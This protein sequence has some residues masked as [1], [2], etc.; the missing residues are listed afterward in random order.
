[1][2]FTG[3]S[4]GAFMDRGTVS[5]FRRVG[6]VLLVLLLA[7]V[8]LSTLGHLPATRV[9]AQTTLGGPLPG[10]TTSQLN[11]FTIGLSQFD[12][13]WDPVHGLGPVY[14][15]TNCNHCHSTPVDGGYSTTNRVTLFGALN[16]DGS[17]NP[18]TNEGGIELQPLTV[19]K[20]IA[21]CTV[22]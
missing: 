7:A 4:E 10:L 11:H 14:T 16:S 5:V 12:F 8:F 21:G 3:F 17:F 1:M 13:S 18:L 6:F 2:V 19:A 22:V 15:N 9:Q 20:F